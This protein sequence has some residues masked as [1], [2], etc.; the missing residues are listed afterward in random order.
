M[1]H[2]T[3][4]IH[5]KVQGVFFRNTTKQMAQK[6]GLCGTVQNL[7]DGSVKVEVEG[8]ENVLNEFLDYCHK[9]PSKAEV[10]DVSVEE[11][12]I[13]GYTDFRVI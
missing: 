11:G 13:V 9:G 6:V 1:K 4:R 12:N 8:E 2:L 5:G 3:I 7:S 10:K